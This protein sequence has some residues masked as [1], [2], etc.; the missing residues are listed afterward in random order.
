MFSLAKGLDWEEAIVLLAIAGGLAMSSTVFYRKGDWRSFEPNPFWLGVVFTAFVALTLF[1]FF[2]FRH[3]EYQNELWWSFAWD[4]DAPRFLRATLALGVFAAALGLDAIVNRPPQRARTGP[5]PVP[6]DVRDLLDACEA[7]QPQIA[8]LGDKRFIVADDRSAFLMYAVS[9]RSWISMG[10]PVGSRQAGYDLIWRMAEAAD[11]AGARAIYYAVGTQYMPA[12]VDLGLSMLKIGEIAR[13]SLPDF[14]LEGSKRQP[15]RYAFKRAEREGLRFEVLPREGVGYAMPQ[16]R[17]VSDAWMELKKGREKG[18]SLGNFNEA[19][20]REFDCAVLT[21]GDDIVAFANLWR[22]AGREELSV[23]LMRYRP[24]V[25]NALMD[26]FFTHLL[27]YGRDE[28][29]RWFNL[30]AAPLSGLSSH[31]LASAWNR[32][33][34][35]IYRRG[36]EFY[37]FEGLR[38]F[39]Q[40]FDPVWTSQYLACPGGLTTG[41]SLIDVA[42]LISGGA[43]GVFKR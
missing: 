9:G 42:S 20:L 4:G 14:T 32:L 5:P 1:G 26:A 34:T 35:F 6:A 39:K 17:A 8:L 43:I 15:L 40:K 18:F 13:V 16:L 2:A 30:G 41:Q 7:T 23:D 10:D 25:S 38:A 11:R 19:Y 12:Y 33:G 24:G 21:Q 29:Y 31:P 37:N 28:G 3:V 27:I 36:D 22:G